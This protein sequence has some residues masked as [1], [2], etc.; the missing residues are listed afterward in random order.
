MRFRAQPRVEYDAAQRALMRE[1]PRE[2]PRPAEAAG[3]KK[4]KAGVSAGLPR[5]PITV[6]SALGDQRRRRRRSEEAVAQRHAEDVDLRV[7]G[8]DEGAE[9]RVEGG[10]AGHQVD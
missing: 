6:I 9:R 3:P 5:P 8:A 4:L 7:G 1:H 2:K 10:I